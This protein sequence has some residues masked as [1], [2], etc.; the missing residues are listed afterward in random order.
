[1]GH[2]LSQISRQNLLR[3]KIGELFIKNRRIDQAGGAQET[4]SKSGMTNKTSYQLSSYILLQG[5]TQ[6]IKWSDG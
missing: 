1:M 3:K 4:G 6:A 5:G 2:F